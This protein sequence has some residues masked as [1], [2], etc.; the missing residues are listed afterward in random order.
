MLSKIAPNAEIFIPSGSFFDNTDTVDS[1][2]H[3]YGEVSDI[4]RTLMSSKQILDGVKPEDFIVVSIEDVLETRDP[5]FAFA[6]KSNQDEGLV[7]SPISGV[8]TLSNLSAQNGAKLALVEWVG[9]ESS[10]HPS[11]EFEPPEFYGLFID[12]NLLNH[13]VRAKLL[14][15]AR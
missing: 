14:D 15:E 9:G 4:H 2:L 5:Y 12:I 3:S 6:I 7:P 11:Q 13:D 8:A 10:L 1:K